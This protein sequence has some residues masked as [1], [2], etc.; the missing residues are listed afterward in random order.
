MKESA[1]SGK[2]ITPL[3]SQYNRI[4]AQYPD[5]ILF[6]RMGDFYE[7]FG[8]DAIKAA[9]IL[10]VALTSRGHMNGEK[11][12]LAGV[13]YH[14]MDKYLVRLLAA[15]EKVVVV[16]QVE[17]PRL[18]K[19]VVK[20]EVVEII[21]PGTATVE[22]VAEPTNSIYL[23]AIFQ[24]D[25]NK[26]GISYIDLLGGK[27]YLDEG[28]K[29]LML[30]RLRVL[31]PQE[32]LYPSGGQPPPVLE[33]IKSSSGNRL[34]PFEEWNFD[35]KTAERELSDFFGASTLDGFGVGSYHKG[36]AAAG[37][38]YRYLRETNRVHLDHVTKITLAETDDYMLLDYNTIRNLEII[39]NLS[40]SSERDS[41]FQTINR[42]ATP[43]GARRLK[44]NLLHPYRR[45]KPILYRQRGVK[46]LYHQRDVSLNISI[47]LKKFPDL[48]R[49]AGRLG[50]R[51]LNPRQL[52]SIRH[53][54]ALSH[55]S[56]W[57]NEDTPIRY[58]CRNAPILPAVR[59]AN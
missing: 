15:G 37:A 14:A 33:D 47:L 57:D 40:E 49:L 32:I 22:G 2:G 29:D 44:D 43:G 41:L 10:N 23:A 19:G 4:K 24:D 59:I 53:R 46:E 58:F 11:I 16:E 8:D 55:G 38:I 56:D 1:R 6:F 18:A 35:Y 26:I 21:T 45:L 20:R 9:P 17:D 13:P 52:E 48:E 36:L 27:F 54:S 51:K 34:T 5:K 28:A 12:P 30:E 39:N 3:M 7:M 31:A 25:A 50:M 42:T